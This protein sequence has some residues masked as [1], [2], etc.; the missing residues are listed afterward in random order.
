MIAVHNHSK[1]PVN[2]ERIANG[3]NLCAER[4]NLSI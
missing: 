3:Y 4:F 1:N 2:E